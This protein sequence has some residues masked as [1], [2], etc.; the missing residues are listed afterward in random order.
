MVGAM[1]LGW[2]RLRDRPVGRIWLWLA[3]AAAGLVPVVA[4]VTQVI[5]LPLQATLL[6]LWLPT[7]A[8]W[9][10][11]WVMARR[12]PEG[13]RRDDPDAAAFERINAASGALEVGDLDA[14]DDGLQAARDRSRPALAPYVE[15]WARLVEEERQRREGVRVSSGP[16]REAMAIEMAR[17]RADRARPAS[18]V[19]ALAVVVGIIVAIAAPAAFGRPTASVDACDQAQFILAAAE[20]RPRAT[21]IEDGSLS[22]LTLLNPGEPAGTV[23]D[24]GLNLQAAAESRHDPLARDKL[25]MAGF[26]AGYHREWV[27]PNGQRAGAEIFRFNTPSGAAQFHRHATEYA[28][29]F[30]NLAFSGPGGGTGLQ[31]RYSTGDR[32]VEQLAWVDGSLRIVVTR[33]FDEPPT[34][35]G[36]IIDLA[37]RASERLAEPHPAGSPI[38]P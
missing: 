32:I 18:A 33:G 4:V 11:S 16:T 17:L 24:A 10:L 23:I 13:V 20:A 3:A 1:Q 38:A 8:A 28:C 36:V 27:L 31:V 21:E 15:L 37:R 34:D 6:A 9:L 5:G 25:A 2:T 30:A 12:L 35:H 7:L 29:R 22:H 14:A 19:V 26:I